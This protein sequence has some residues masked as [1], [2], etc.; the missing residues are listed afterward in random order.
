MR[1]STVKLAV[2]GIVLLLVGGVVAIAENAGTVSASTCQYLASI[3]ATPAGCAPVNYTAAIVL[4]C[5]GAG[6]LFLAFVVRDT[7]HED[8]KPSKPSKMVKPVK[9]GAR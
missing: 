2:T 4:A 1:I 9:L 6:L 3:G 7:S 8:P 5:V